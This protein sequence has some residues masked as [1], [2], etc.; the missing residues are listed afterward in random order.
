[1]VLAM[2]NYNPEKMVII[3]HRGASSN[4]PENTLKAFKKAIELKADYIELDLHETKDGELVIT[5]DEDLYRITGK[6][7]LIKNFT[8]EQLKSL[9]FGEGEKIP[10][11]QEVIKLIKGKISLNCEIKVKNISKKVIKVLKE[12]QFID[13]VIISSFLHDELLKFQKTEPNLKLA[14]LE[15]VQY[16]KKYTWYLKKKMIQFCANNN[17][18]AINPFYPIVDQQFV[19]LAHNHNIRVFPWTVDLK[20]S[21]KKLLKFGVD[22][23]ITNDVKKAKAIINQ[24]I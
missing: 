8:L 16:E 12:Y 11:I 9:N 13:S 19:D 23:I 20:P 24:E 15:P 4:A 2:K 5:H 14:S 18:F 3:A 10:T 21:I 17:L 7:G 22:G 1:M 6:T